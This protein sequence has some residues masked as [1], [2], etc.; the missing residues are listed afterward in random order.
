MSR[1]KGSRTSGRKARELTAK[2][3]AFVR[4]YSVDNNAT[5]AAIRA[6]YSAKTASVLG[7]QLLQIPLVR[8][9]IAVEQRKL[10]ERTEVTVDRVV[11]ELAAIAFAD[12]A[13][14]A[15]IDEVEIDEY[16]EVKDPDTRL[17]RIVTE[18]RKVQTVLLTNTRSLTKRQR[19]AISEIKHEFD[20]HGNRAIGVKL[21]DKTRALELLGKHLGMWADR[22]D[23]KAQAIVEVLIEKMR[24]RVPDALYAAL[25]QF[26]AQ[27]MGV[28]EVAPE[29]ASG[30]EAAVH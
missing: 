21:H 14:F 26:I 27:E 6:K 2:Q 17:T 28:G 10:A 12:M 4:E 29:T 30:S 13:D 7:Y 11:E 19:K 16:T 3:K 15:E 24:G 23:G 20:R 18:R 1:K 9:A 22:A 25:V 5:Q 8:D